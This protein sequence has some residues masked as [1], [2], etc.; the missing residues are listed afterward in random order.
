MRR[1]RFAF[2]LC[3]ALCVGCGSF[4]DPSRASSQ[5]HNENKGKIAS[6]KSETKYSAETLPFDTPVGA[7]FDWKSP[8]DGPYP[9]KSKDD[10]L[11]IDVSLREQRI[12][13]MNGSK[14]IYTMI[15]SSGL[16][17]TDT[18]TPTGTY[19]V[20]QQRGTWFYASQY[21]EGAKYWVSWKGHGE[22]LFH[23]LP[24]DKNHQ[25]IPDQVAK[26]GVKSSHGCFHLTLA[27][28]KWIYDSIPAGTKVVIHN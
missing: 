14:I 5:I 19:Y 16:N 13:I 18:Q 26:L 10:F 7:N 15:T 27:D 25:V 12:Y 6:S 1:S 2:Y 24:M 28:A 21:Q 11:W 9:V 8:S 17:G 23:S 22:F 3:V 4:R 20:Q